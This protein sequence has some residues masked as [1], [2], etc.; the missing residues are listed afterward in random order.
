MGPGYKPHDPLAGLADAPLFIVPRVLD[1]L[2]AYRQQAT[3]PAIDA[4][5]E[6]LLAGVAAHPTRFWV[7]KQF[8]QTLDAADSDALRAQLAVEL[9]RLME[10][11]GIDSSNGILGIDRR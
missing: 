1:A 3:L 8:Q 10:M 2:R 4:L 6:R 7:L 11:L 5:V 9:E